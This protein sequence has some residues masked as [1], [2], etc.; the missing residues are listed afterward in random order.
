MKVKQIALALS[1]I[2]IT[3]I[4]SGCAFN[5]KVEQN[6][7]SNKYFGG[8]LDYKKHPTKMKDVPAQLKDDLKD[9]TNQFKHDN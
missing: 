2:S 5:K 4:L 1:I 9:T 8:I 6:D 3:V 7:I